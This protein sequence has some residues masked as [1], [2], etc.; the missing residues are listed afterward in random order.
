MGGVSN[1]HSREDGGPARRS[2]S[3]FP[4]LGKRKETV[5]Y[6]IN[7]DTALAV[8]GVFAINIDRD[9]GRIAQVQERWRV[10]E[11]GSV[12]HICPVQERRPRTAD[13]RP[14]NGIDRNKLETLDPRLETIQSAPARDRRPKGSGARKAERRKPDR[15]SRTGQDDRRPGTADRRDEGMTTNSWNGWNDWNAGEAPRPRRLVRRLVNSA[16]VT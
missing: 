1:R 3:Q 7:R 13:R 4:S 5:S 15:R 16:I 9:S 2:V 11:L 14:R 6:Q 12:V 8:R 10:T